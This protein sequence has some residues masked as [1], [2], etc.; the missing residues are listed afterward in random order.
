MDFKQVAHALVEKAND[1]RW[2]VLRD[3]IEEALRDAYAAGVTVGSLKPEPP[4]LV[5]SY[6]TDGGAPYPV[7]GCAV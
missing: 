1:V 5:A 2:H 7:E 3:Q 6:D 4:A